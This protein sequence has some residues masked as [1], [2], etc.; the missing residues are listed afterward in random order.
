MLQT[1]V[2]SQVGASC[3]AAGAKV[4]DL[5]YEPL[6]QIAKWQ[7]QIFGSKDD[8]GPSTSSTDDANFDK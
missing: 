3:F 7:E 6:S 2:F 4:R 1:Y 5:R 8:Q